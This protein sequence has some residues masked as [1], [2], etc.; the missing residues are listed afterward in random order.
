VLP[1][2]HIRPL[3]GELVAERDGIM[4]VEQD[5]VVTH[6]QLE[7]R[8]NDEAVFNGARNGTHVQNFVRANGVFSLHD[9]LD[10]FRFDLRARDSS[11]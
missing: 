1:G 6:W 4:I 7:P 5:E 10:F 9:V 8:L 3:R 11:G 2:E